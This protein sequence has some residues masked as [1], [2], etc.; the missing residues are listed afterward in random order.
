MTTIYVRALDQVLEATISP[1]IASGNRETV[2][3]SVEFS[4]HWDGF[5]KSAVFYTSKSP[6]PYSRPLSVNGL[7]TIPSEV[8]AD[9]C[10]LFISVQGVNVTTGAVKA[11]LPVKYKVDTGAPPLV[12]SDPTPDVYQ[13]LLTAYGKAGNELAVE[14]ARIDALLRL[15]EGSTTGDAELQDIRIG[16]DGKTYESAGTAVREQINAQIETDYPYPFTLDSGLVRPGYPD[17]TPYTRQNA[18]IKDLVIFDESN[19]DDYFV[20]TLFGYAP[21][22]ICRIQISNEDGTIVGT[23]EKAV[24]SSNIPVSDVETVELKNNGVVIARAVVDWVKCNRG[25]GVDLTIASHKVREACVDR[26]ASSKAMLY[27]F[28]AYSEIARPGYSEQIVYSSRKQGIKNL[29]VY[30][31]DDKDYYVRELW[32]YG[33]GVS[34]IVVNSED[35]TI[36][37]K[38][39]ASRESGDNL[40]TEDV[41]LVDKAGKV[42]AIATIDWSKINK[43]MGLDLTP[44]VTKIQEA[45]IRR[46]RKNSLPYI[47]FVPISDYYV[48]TRQQRLYL[49]EV[50]DYDKNGY[51]LISVDGATYPEVTTGTNGVSEYIEFNVAETKEFTVTVKYYYHGE[52]VDGI[53]ITVHATAENLPTKKYM[54][55]GDS[56]TDAGHMQNYFKDENNG[57]VLYGTRGSGAYL[58]EGR[59]GWTVGDYFAQSKNGLVNPFYN[60]ST[61]TFDFAYYM[62]NHASFADVDIVNIFIGRNNGFNTSVISHI[63]KMIESIKAYK[64]EIIV[65]LMG[66][67]NVACDSSGT[68]KYMQS[69]GEFNFVAH[70]YNKEFYSHFGGA[71]IPAHCNLDNKNDYTVEEKAISEFDE[72]TEVVY[73]DNVHPDERGYKKFAVAISA[74]FKHLLNE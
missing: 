58:H 11:T 40:P 2:L 61:A 34:Q 1:R 15:E 7:C 9:D 52:Y 67:Y 19:G 63:D 48:A 14:R 28:T 39:S 69:A 3:L 25:T 24:D 56:L 70:K 32:A 29:V 27:P 12:V 36:S 55:I 21:N 33:N 8:L 74:Y 41:E 35:D 5:A 18:C 66:A 47:S 45:C 68:G 4:E 65:T 50:A 31:E 44:E 72:R 49:N 71:V 30:A 6:V 53:T 73:T 54:F 22:G 64:T 59:S 43:A 51:F 13:E 10:R 17:Q 23:Y 60:P 26:S 20:K 42:I 16:A 62:K 38:Y 57:V 37:G 46:Y